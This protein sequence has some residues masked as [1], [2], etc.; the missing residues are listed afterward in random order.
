LPTA[1]GR[2]RHDAARA[3]A[4]RQLY[5]ERAAHRVADHVRCVDAEFVEMV[6]Q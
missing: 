3:T 2:E 4:R 1:A 5:R 6:F